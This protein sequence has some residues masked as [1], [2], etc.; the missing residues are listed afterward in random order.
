[1]SEKFAGQEK[2]I[3]LEGYIIINRR[4]MGL[5]VK[6]GGA[7][8]RIVQRKFKIFSYYIEMW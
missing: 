1:M 5:L 4:K 3:K 2:Y 7:R 8:C 6:L